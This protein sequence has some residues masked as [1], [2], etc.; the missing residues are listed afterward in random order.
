MAQ[1]LR[2]FPLLQRTRVQFPGSV[3]VSIRSL[4]LAPKNLMP[5]SGFLGHY[6]A[7]CM[8]VCARVHTHTHTHTHTHKL[9]KGLER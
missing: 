5:F 4:I 2:V 3:S 8:H 6:L 9:I 7:V 1:T